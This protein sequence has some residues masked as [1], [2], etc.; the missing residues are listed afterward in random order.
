MLTADPPAEVDAERY[1]REVERA[2]AARRAEEEQTP[3]P[4]EE[5]C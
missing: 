2:A 3:Q 4:L 1:A 5:S